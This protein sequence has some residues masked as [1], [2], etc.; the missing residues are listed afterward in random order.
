V[1]LTNGDI[2]YEALTSRDQ[3]SA[4][5]FSKLRGSLQQIFRI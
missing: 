1:K 2:A 4:E 5:K 3:F